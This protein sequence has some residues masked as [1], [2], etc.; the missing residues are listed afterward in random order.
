[1]ATVTFPELHNNGITTLNGAINGSVTTINL[2]TGGA[3]ALG[4]DNS[5]TDAYLTIIDATTWRKNPL[6]SPETLEIVQVTAV[7][8]DTLTV[9]RG[10][11]GTSGIAFADG[12]IVELR[13]P[14]IVTQRITDALTDGTD[15]LNIGGLVSAGDV[16]PATE[17]GAD[18]GSTTLPFKDAHVEKLYFFPSNAGSQPSRSHYVLGNV[19]GSTSANWL[20][21]F[22]EDGSST[23][24]LCA[25][26]FGDQSF[27]VVGDLETTGGDLIVAG[28]ADVDGD[29]N[30]P[31][32]FLNFGASTEVTVASGVLAVSGVGSNI[33][34]AGE[35]GVADTV[36]S[37]TGG[38]DGDILILRA[39]DD[40]V[41]ITISDVG[42]IQ[43]PSSR[44][45]DSE[46]DTLVLQ[47]VVGGTGNRWCEIS[48][49][50]NA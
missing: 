14:A 12:S 30:I 46:F 40:T 22:I 9:T 26:F 32:G 5:T 8:T 15:E 47:F 42:N 34:V 2:A 39:A 45:L 17:R 29:V 28:D 49:S 37:I 18:I 38:T 24:Q 44:T 13:N 25:Q 23:P 31:T 35:G 27:K 33:K 20:K 19:S 1:M 21:V 50:D 16:T 10:V 4:L 36:S 6:T 41:D 3:A 48:F 11:D 43:L 7:S